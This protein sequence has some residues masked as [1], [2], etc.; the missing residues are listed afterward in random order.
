MNFDNYGIVWNLDHK[1]PVALQK[2]SK[3]TFELVKTIAH[4]ENI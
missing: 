4:Y 2:N 1:D 3:V